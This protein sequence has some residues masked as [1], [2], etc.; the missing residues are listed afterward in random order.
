MRRHVAR[1]TCIWWRLARQKPW[2]S[3]CCGSARS[4][5]LHNAIAQDQRAA[6]APRR[7]TC[8]AAK[9]RCW[10]LATYSTPVRS[11]PLNHRQFRNRLDRIERDQEKAIYNS[12]DLRRR[13]LHILRDQMPREQLVPFVDA[14]LSMPRDEVRALLQAEIDRQQT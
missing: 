13:L 3:E 11:D 1:A 5:K 7:N 2:R 8:R 12:D 6:L 9:Q 14:L 10:P 4:R